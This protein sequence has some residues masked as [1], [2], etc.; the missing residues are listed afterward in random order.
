MPTYFGQ[1]TGD[2][3]D[4]NTNRCYFNANKIFTCPG[5]GPQTIVELAIYAKKMTNNAPTRVA[6]YDT[7]LNKICQGDA[8]ITINSETEQW[9]THTSFT[10]TTQIVG[11]T[12][13]VLAI[14]WGATN[15]YLYCDTTNGSD[16]DYEYVGADYTGGFPA[17]LVPDFT[18]SRLYCIRC[19]VDPAAGGLSWSG[20]GILTDSGAYSRKLNLGRSEAGVL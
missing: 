14:A 3:W 15:F 17:T 9:W 18:G 6:I 13:Y 1:Q 11:G 20:T 8:A 16:G 4:D 19:G 5:S 7:S 10:G 12:D 2:G